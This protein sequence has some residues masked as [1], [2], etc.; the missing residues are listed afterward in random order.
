M[1]LYPLPGGRE[2]RREP[3][4]SVRR[5]WAARRSTAFCATDSGKNVHER[6][7]HIHPSQLTLSLLPCVIQGTESCSGKGQGWG[8]R[9]QRIWGEDSMWCA[10]GQGMEEGLGGEGH[11]MLPRAWC[12][13][14]VGLA[15]W[16]G[17]C[18]CYR[19]NLQQKPGLV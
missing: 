5:L 12:V 9:G 13:Q 14:V 16:Q 18:E 8:A 7:L 1:H 6:A 10:S 17:T 11:M 2:A 3:W 19:R 4:Q 15:M